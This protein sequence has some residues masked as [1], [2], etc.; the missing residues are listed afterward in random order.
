YFVGRGTTA[1]WV[2]NGMGGAGCGVPKAREVSGKKA[3]AGRAA[4]SEDPQFGAGYDAIFGTTKR[5]AA[6]TSRFQEYLRQVEDFTGVTLTK[7]QAQRLE[8]AWAQHNKKLLSP[9]DYAKHKRQ[10]ERPGF[11]DKVID[12]WERQT[13]RKWPVHTEDVV[14]KGEILREK[15]KR[16]DAHHLLE[17]GYGGPHEWWNIHPARYP[18]IHQGKIHG[19]EGIV[20]ELM[21]DRK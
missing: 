17:K 13:G 15:G 11:K 5:R 18:D 1:V 4:M 21:P 7:S 2:H 19:K 10:W 3:G 12:E 16:L 9:T 14:I 8:S 20:R 6:P